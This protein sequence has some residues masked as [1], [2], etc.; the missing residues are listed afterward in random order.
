VNDGT[1]V[2]PSPITKPF[3]VRD[4]EFGSKVGM[5]EKTNPA[6]SEVVL[7]AG[8]DPPI[9]FAPSDQ[10]EEVS[11]FQRINEARESGVNAKTNSPIAAWRKIGDFMAVP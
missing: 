9:Q 8:A 5:A 2:A 6:W 4:P 3:T 10:S 1:A 7:F 11:P